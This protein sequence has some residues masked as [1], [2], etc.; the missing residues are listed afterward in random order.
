M[1]V[2]PEHLIPRD[3]SRDLEGGKLRIVPE[4]SDGPDR[5][6][7][8]DGERSDLFPNRAYLL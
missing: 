7:I 6:A 3:L 2:V 1:D 8:T 4:L 5:V